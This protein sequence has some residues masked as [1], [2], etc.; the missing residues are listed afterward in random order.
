MKRLKSTTKSGN[1]IEKPASH[2]AGF[3]SGKLCKYLYKKWSIWL[4]MFIFLLL[5]DKG[6]HF[7]MSRYPGF[8]LYQ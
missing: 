6:M 5:T 8:A 4:K 3:F 7:S 2:E 1:T